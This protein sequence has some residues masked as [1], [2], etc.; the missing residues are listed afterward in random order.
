MDVLIKYRN[1]RKKEGASLSELKGLDGRINALFSTQVDGESFDIELLL[2]R[3]QIAE[4]YTGKDCPDFL[5]RIDKYIYIALGSKPA[6]VIDVKVCF[7]KDDAKKENV[8][9][10]DLN[11]EYVKDL[12]QKAA[13]VFGL[14]PNTINLIFYGKHLNVLTNTLVDVPNLGNNSTVYICRKIY[15][16]NDCAELKYGMLCDALLRDTQSM[17]KD[18]TDEKI[19]NL[20]LI[21]SR[22]NSCATEAVCTKPQ[23]SSKLLSNKSFDSVIDALINMPKP[24]L[25]HERLV[26]IRHPDWEGDSNSKVSILCNKLT[27]PMPTLHSKS[28]VRKKNRI[29]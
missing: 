1:E 19:H 24:R 18:M 28:N 25:S 2:Y 22:M 14:K 4:T 21:Y 6:C 26:C 8:V 11:N 3:K 5:S 13:S 27:E 15:C 9:S 7:V 17:F 12:L 16:D 10:V 23:L 20:F 29:Y